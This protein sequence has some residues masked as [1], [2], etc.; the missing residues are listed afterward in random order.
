MSTASSS[1][2]TLLLV[3]LDGR[4]LEQQYQT[5]ERRPTNGHRS[6]VRAWGELL[7]GSVEFELLDHKG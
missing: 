1:L 3:I 4:D 6:A 5:T 2:R 7:I